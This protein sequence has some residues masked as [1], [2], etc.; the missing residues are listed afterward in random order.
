MR[1][2]LLPLVCAMTFSGVACDR[3]EDKKPEG[4]APEASKA[5]PAE[6]EIPSLE[7]AQ[8]DPPV[9]GPVPP[10]TSMA[11]FSIEGALVPLACFIKE[12]NS[13]E[14]GSACLELAKAGAE[15]RVA[16][17]DA[18]Y[19]KIAQDPVEPQC[20]IGS[21]KNV[22]VGVEGIT[23]GASFRF[24]VWPRSTMKLVKMVDR[25]T[26]SA[27]ETR[28][29]ED[30]VAKLS[31]AIKSAGGAVGDEL[32]AHQVAELDLDGAEPA[33]KV[34]SVFSPNPK[35]A[36][37]YAW[38]GLFLAPG[39]DLAALQLIDQSKSKRDVLEVNATLDLDGDGKQELWTR[40]VFEDGAGDRVVS[41]KGSKPKPLGDW[42]CGAGV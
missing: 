13:L 21:G 31:A 20:L 19:N 36:E 22:A 25:I 42:S 3:G 39:G 10:E 16:S 33:E 35:M 30:E 23:E 2:R 28:L 26:T 29:S 14:T 38:S 27:K 40:L 34:Y 11:L 6:D 12:K 17:E 4:P 1:V 24:G 15:V 37:Q 8:G 7:V 32:K 41:L 18:E 5:P 9:E